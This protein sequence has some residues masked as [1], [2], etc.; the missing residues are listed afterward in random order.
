[1][2][3]SASEVNLLSFL[4]SVFEHRFGLRLSCSCCVLQF[5]FVLDF[6]LLPDG[7]CFPFFVY[8][9]FV[10]CCHVLELVEVVLVLLLSELEQA[11]LLSCQLGA[12]LVLVIVLVLFIE[13]FLEPCL[14]LDLCLIQFLIEFLLIQIV[15]VLVHCW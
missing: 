7:H 1:M 11:L 14:V 10:H 4:L 9:L 6:G 15:Y 3:K 13:I 2:A 5:L 12:I 8:L